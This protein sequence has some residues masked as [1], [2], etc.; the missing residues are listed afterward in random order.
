M[1]ALFISLGVLYITK[2]N[3]HRSYFYFRLSNN[4]NLSLRL[5]SV[6]QLAFAG[7]R[8]NVQWV[9]AT[10]LEPGTKESDPENF[11]LSW[12]SVK[13]SDGILVPGAANYELYFVSSSWANH[14]VQSSASANALYGR[15]F[16]NFQ[17]VRSPP[18]A[19]LSLL[20]LSPL[21]LALSLPPLRVPYSLCAILE[22]H[23]SPLSS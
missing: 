5:P 8:L 18:M 19:A 15:L 11:N 16:M 20:F 12:E 2:F 10:A 23:T 7:R 22:F 14:A 6:L 13:G 9:D 4:F 17:L 21:P 3:L 1:S